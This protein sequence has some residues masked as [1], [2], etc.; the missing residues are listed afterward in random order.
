MTTV[1]LPASAV[2]VSPNPR[3]PEV[4]PLANL[5]SALMSSHANG[6]PYDLVSPVMQSCLALATVHPFDTTERVPYRRGSIATDLSLLEAVLNLTNFN[7]TS[8][9]YRPWPQTIDGFGPE[10]LKLPGPAS[11]RPLQVDTEWVAAALVALG[12]TPWSAAPAG[13]L[14]SSVQ[15]AA[16]N[17][18][19]GLLERFLALPGAWSAQAIA[20]APFTTPHGNGP[21]GWSVLV[22]RPER[23]AALGVLLKNGARPADE[24][25]AVGLLSAA[26]PE[27]VE[28]LAPYLSS[29]SAAGRKKVESAWRSR[30]QSNDLSA[31][32]LGRM[33]AA[34]WGADAA[35]QLSA[36]AVAIAQD[37]A[38]AWGT[39]SNGS[40]GRA[41]GFKGNMGVEALLGRGK[42]KTG[43]LAGQ[44]N[45]LASSV[46]SRIRQASSRGALGWSVNP[47]MFSRF[48]DGK[49]WVS[50]E[51]S[52]PPYKYALAPA[53]GFDWRPGVPI[54][55]I[56]L[57]GLLGQ[58]EEGSTNAEIRAFLAATGISSDPATDIENLRLWA[59]KHVGGAVEVTK[60]ACSGNATTAAVRMLYT[61]HAL[62]ARVKETDIL[63]ALAPQQRFELLYA[64]TGKFKASD[65]WDTSNPGTG[66]AREQFLALAT[67]LFPNL[68]SVE[69]LLQQDPSGVDFRAALVM[70]LALTRSSQ[71]HQH[72]IEVLA[73][74]HAR[75][76]EEVFGLLETW[77]KATTSLSSD[78]SKH[79][80]A[81]IDGWRLDR[82]LAASQPPS[83]GRSKPRF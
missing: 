12:C 82:R 48:E 3:Q 72:L 24:E 75:L 80:Q 32:G 62:M 52:K 49:G 27:A 40:S 1:Q 30:A 58:E 2:P 25:A 46:F 51:S 67:V 23:S 14:P 77:A 5:L 78:A 17:G 9:V 6:L 41:Y 42:V 65:P 57:L 45:Q 47:M 29:L 50:A 43:P 8:H 63:E 60:Q 11:H 21:Q 68:P 38:V 16:E 7:A 28:T 37:L 73:T 10:L 54:D 81:M 83:P 61:W 70:E 55:S 34:L 44:W 69:E 79:C 53:L 13:S 20:D 71:K 56:L 76:P 66:G 18:M 22:N 15:L 74:E 19:A 33:S 36:A 35:E 31:Q 64:L 4:G 39:P 59:K 26:C